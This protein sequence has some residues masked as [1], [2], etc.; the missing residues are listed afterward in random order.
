[1]VASACSLLPVPSDAL[2]P[3][4]GVITCAA[5]DPPYA[6]AVLAADWSPAAVALVPHQHP[7]DGIPLRH[8]VVETHEVRYRSPTPV[9]FLE[10]AEAIAGG[11]YVVA[12]AV[13]A[14]ALGPTRSPWI[15]ASGRA[16][17]PLR[18]LHRLS[19]NRMAA[20]PQEHLP[21]FRG[22]NARGTS[23]RIAPHVSAARLSTAGVATRGRGS[24]TV[25]AP[26]P[27][28]EGHLHTPTSSLAAQ[29][30]P[31]VLES[32]LA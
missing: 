23:K 26:R 10:Q 14:H 8:L 20:E 19:G 9:P 4:S 1:M 25:V 31:D 7:G 29:C 22:V 17:K 24:L 6:S 21:P 13:A 16:G 12:P 15:V 11:T 28:E 32:I 27:A 18:S 2:R 30:R 3:P 5:Q